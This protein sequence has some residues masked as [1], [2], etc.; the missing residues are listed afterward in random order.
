MVRRLNIQERMEIYK[1]KLN[2]HN[3][4]NDKIHNQ[5]N[6]TFNNLKLTSS[7]ISIKHRRGGGG[8]GG[9]CKTTPLRDEAVLKQ[10]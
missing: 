5:Q 2:G 10:F 8:I 1:E 9:L 7:T 3:N 4:K 6:V